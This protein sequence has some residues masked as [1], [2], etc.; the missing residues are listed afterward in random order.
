[1]KSKL[2]KTAGTI[3]LV[4][5]IVMFGCMILAIVSWQQFSW[6]ESALSDLGIQTGMTAILFNGVL[7][8]SGLLFIFFAFGLFKFVGKKLV[9]RIGSGLFIVA[10]TFLVMIGII[11]ESFGPTHYI[12]ALTFFSFLL[13]SLMFLSISFWQS[14]KRKLS[15]FT[16]ISILFGATIWIL[17]FTLHYVQGV[18]V[19]ETVSGVMGATWVLVLSYFF[20]RES[21]KK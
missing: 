12:V 13:I 6:T 15:L 20:L 17:Q 1:L 4:T 14:G 10:S 19:P 11:N 9:G 7:I 3:G 21:S 5:P 8:V 2:L 18:A 16:L